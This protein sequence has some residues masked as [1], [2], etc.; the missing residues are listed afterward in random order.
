MLPSIHFCWLNLLIILNQNLYLLE[1]KIMI[2]AN[3]III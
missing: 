2:F 3:Y 1:M